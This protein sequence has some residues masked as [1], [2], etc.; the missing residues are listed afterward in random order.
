MLALRHSGEQPTILGMDA[1]TTHHCSQGYTD[2]GIVNLNNTPA[3]SN[4]LSNVHFELD[5]K[6]D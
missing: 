4:F 6:D 5:D 3:H 2:Q 1:P